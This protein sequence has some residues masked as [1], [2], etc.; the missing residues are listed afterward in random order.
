MTSKILAQLNDKMKELSSKQN[1]AHCCIYRVPKSL[2]IVN[3][4]AYTPLLI[5]IGPLHREKFTEQDGMNK[6]K[7]RD[8]VVIIQNK[9]NNIR[10]CYSEKFNQIN[11]LIS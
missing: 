8:L 6:E 11:S 9:E 5:S 1:R 2:R 3:W 4:K 10:F 7:I